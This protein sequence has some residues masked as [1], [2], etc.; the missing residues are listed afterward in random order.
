MTESLT[1][2]TTLSATPKQIYTAWLSSKGHT[3]MTGGE[4]K[5]N[6]TIGKTF[7]AWDGYITGKNM[8]LEPNKRIVQLWRTSEFPENAPDSRLEILLEAVKGG[9]KM[10]LHHTNIPKGQKQQYKQGWQDHYF[11][12]M[13]SYFGKAS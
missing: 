11:T 1:V 5:C 4:A 6:A 7:T 8:E 3:A 9:T 13:K 12:P 10:T 2:S